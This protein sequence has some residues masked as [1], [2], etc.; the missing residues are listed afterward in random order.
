MRAPVLALALLPTLAH[1][2]H[3]PA[4]WFGDVSV[5][6]NVPEAAEAVTPPVEWNP[7]VASAQSSV[8]AA[9]G[10][11]LPAGVELLPNAVIPWAAGT[12]VRLRPRVHG[13]AVEG[14]DWLVSFDSRRTLKRLRG[15][16]FVPPEPLE[17]SLSAV[18]A[19]QRGAE[20]LVPLV[21]RVLQ[22]VGEVA[23]Q[24]RADLAGTWHLCW[25]LDLGGG[26][27]LDTWSLWVDARDGRVQHA[28]PRGRTAQADVYPQNPEVSELETVDL[29]A[30][31]GDGGRLVGDDA[32]VYSCDQWDG[33]GFGGGSCSEKSRHAVPDG[34]GDY[35][36]EPDPTSSEDPLA[37]VMMY[38]HLGIVSRW[39]AEH[40]GFFHVQPMRGIVN[41]DYNNA[42]YGDGDGDGVADVS[43]GQGGG[44]DFAYD[45]DVIYHE[46]GHS[47]IG[48]VAETT[49]SGADEYGLEFAN[50]SLN[51]GSADLFSLAITQN[52]RL[53]EYA[54][55][56]GMG[57]GAI[58][59]L[60]AD[61]RCPDALYGE[62]HKD[63]ETWGAMGWNMIEDT[64][65]GPVLTAQAAYGAA[66][67]W[68]ADVSWA[69]A[70]ESF[71][72]AVEDMEDDGAIDSEQAAAFRSHL[73]GSGVLGCGRVVDLTDGAEPTLFMLNAGLSGEA[74]EVP[75]SLQFKLRAPE[76]TDRLRFRID[77]LRASSD[78]IGWVVFVRRGEAIL[79]EV[80]ELPFLGLPFPVPTEFDERFEGEEDGFEL[81][82]DASSDP[83][84]EAGEDYYF[85]VASRNLGGIDAFQFVTAE[86]TVSGDARSPE[87]AG[88]D[89]DDSA[90]PDDGEGC[91]GCE[92]GSAGATLPLAALALGMVMRRRSRRVVA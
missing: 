53:G 40:T 34:A 21:G 92:Q 10:G 37:E 66:T 46:F 67:T 29:T 48:R 41:F 3:P 62:S 1:A 61:R 51:E 49:F 35:F 75:L 23:L 74:E 73:E 33:G 78:E 27:P 86:I 6:P 56:G 84:L 36:F 68:E 44:I 5:A 89:D 16:V 45:A 87:V 14:R 25:R 64:R 28:E 63:G 38:H 26:A 59:D 72:E 13:H 76:G 88:N 81:V 50:G 42:F 39:F 60:E 47:V 24:W 79:H 9:W 31:D 77:D 18:E 32:D 71:A 4:P 57:V 82:L 17:P 2:D 69:I 58:R 54:G 90:T 8:Q 15:E 70:G 91:E 11:V 22:P 7:L 85:S 80:V 20:A 43:F 12:R 52:P 65:I 55:T 19:A 83:V 30:L